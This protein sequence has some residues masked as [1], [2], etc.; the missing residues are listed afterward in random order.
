[1]GSKLLD[2]FNTHVESAKTV[3]A[4]ISHDRD[5]SHPAQ[6][7]LAARNALRLDRQAQEQAQTAQVQAVLPVF[8]N[9]AEELATA[10]GWAFKTEHVRSDSDIDSTTL[11]IRSARFDLSKD[12]YGEDNLFALQ[13]NVAFGADGKPDVTAMMTVQKGMEAL[14]EA[15]DA[16]PRIKW[17]DRITFGVTLKSEEQTLALLENWTALQATPDYAEEKD[18]LKKLQSHSPKRAFQDRPAGMRFGNWA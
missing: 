16:T 9:L 18:R 4:K 10:K 3:I 15:F 7:R 11:T 13:I 14:L 2:K 1:M 12:H 17:Q 6:K 5:K 8:S